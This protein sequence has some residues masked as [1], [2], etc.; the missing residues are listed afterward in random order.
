M[1]GPVRRLPF[2]LLGL[3]TVATFGGPVAF[4]FV[5]GGGVRPV[6]PPDRP[7]EWWALG[8]ISGLVLALMIACIAVGLSNK[9][10]LD[11]SKRRPRHQSD[12]GPAEG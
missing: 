5:L 10:T 9:Q 1:A 7:V 8:G 2:V 3:M 11:G 4:G 12:Q 6:W